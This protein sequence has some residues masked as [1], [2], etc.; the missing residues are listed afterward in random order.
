M[1]QLTALAKCPNCYKKA[2]VSAAAEERLW[3]CQ[4]CGYQAMSNVWA[5][6][7]QDVIGKEY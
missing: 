7:L 6:K 4:H 3:C 5:T 1:P 2:E